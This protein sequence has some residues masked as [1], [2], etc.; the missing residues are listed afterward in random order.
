MVS[1]GEPLGSSERRGQ[2]LGTRKLAIRDDPQ[3]P[4]VMQN[5]CQKTLVFTDENTPSARVSTQTRPHVYVQNVPVCTGITRTH[6]E[7]CVRLVPVQTE[8]F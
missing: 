8:T 6:V 1:F 7:T 2:I 5:K 3:H 4:V